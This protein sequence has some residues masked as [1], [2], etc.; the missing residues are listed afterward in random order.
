MNIQKLFSWNKPITENTSN[1]AATVNQNTQNTIS[2]FPAS[3][4]GNVIT[5]RQENHTDKSDS[6]TGTSDPLTETIPQPTPTKG[7]MNSPEIT[8]FFDDK[9]FGLGRHNGSTFKSQ[10]ALELGKKSLISKF[11][12]TL[13]T[14]SE[15]K[16]AKINKLQL[17][18]ISI[19]G[20]S[21]PLST[22]LR[23]ACDQLN[24]EINILKDQ[25]E[26]A[27]NQK[28]WVLDALNRYQ[29]GFL[30]GLNDSIEFEILAG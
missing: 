6:G 25:V 18:I 5:L 30:K 4:S 14:L 2:E 23:L 21:A 26:N 12:N 22:K 3:I 28:G 1:Q 17:E 20:L 9:Y 13:I 29:I 24:R 8:E 10:E 11:Q 16:Q 15:R 27:G 19:E 7:L